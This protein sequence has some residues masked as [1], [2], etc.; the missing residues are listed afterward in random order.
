MV[1]DL[2]W[3]LVNSSLC[4][5]FV[6]PSIVLGLHVNADLKVMPVCSVAWRIQVAR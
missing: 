4:Y 3:E 2:E 1:V 6:L 5:L